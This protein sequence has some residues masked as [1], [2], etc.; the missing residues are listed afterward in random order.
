M[1]DQ[2]VG[3]SRLFAPSLTLM[4][5]WNPWSEIDPQVQMSFSG[6]EEGVGSKTS[7]NSEGEMGTLYGHVAKANPQWKEM[8]VREALAIFMGPDQQF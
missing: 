3:A 7:W 4:N 8:P 6:P 1:K 2:D 5:A